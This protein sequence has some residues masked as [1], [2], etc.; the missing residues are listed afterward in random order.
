MTDLPTDLRP[1]VLQGHVIDVLRS[2]PAE[3]VQCCVTSPPYWGL[4]SYGT[5]PQTWGGDPAHE[6]EWKAT[7]PRRASEESSANGNSKKQGANPG[8]FTIGTEGGELCAG[9]GA[10]RGELGLEPT[11]ELYVEHIS[12]VFAEVRRV[13]REDGTLWLNLGDSY[14]STN[15]FSRATNG[16]AR[17]GRS[18]GSADKREVTGLK[19]KDLVGIPWRVAF[20]LQADGWWLR[21]DCVWAKPNPMPESVTDRPTRSHEYVFLLTKAER[22]FYD[23]DAVRGEART[24]EPGTN[25]YARTTMVEVRQGYDGEATKPYED[26]MAQDAS[27]TKSRIIEG[28]K[29]RREL[30]LKGG[31]NLKTVWWV[32]TQP[33]PEAHFATFPEEIAERCIRAGTSERG[34]CATCGAAR[35]RQ[36]KRDPEPAGLRHDGLK[37]QSQR[38]RGGIN[39]TTAAWWAK[40]PRRTLGFSP[41]CSCPTSDPVGCIVLDPFAGSGTTLEVARRLGRRSV[42]IELKAEYVALARRRASTNVPDIESFGERE[43]DDTE[44]RDVA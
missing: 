42:G 19:P 9:C 33:Y 23:A 43:R 29:R 22:Y 27:A 5:P 6:H 12:L 41:T 1:L 32:A 38:T 24:Q 37:Y 34:A 17:G 35:E 21:S 15:G 11:P 10:W 13:L 39:G 8:S 3:S 25:G 2:L 28:I 40:N 26:T 30:G 18:G 20:R 4:R 16:W 7:A 36:A 44:V 14:N 31:S